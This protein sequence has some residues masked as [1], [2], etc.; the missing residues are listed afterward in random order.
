MGLQQN[1]MSKMRIRQRK[2]QN[3]YRGLQFNNCPHCGAK[4]LPHCVCQKCG[5]Y[6]DM[7]VLT[8]TSGE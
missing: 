6:R 3:R 5:F 8:I 1:K 2:A 4:R 7:Q